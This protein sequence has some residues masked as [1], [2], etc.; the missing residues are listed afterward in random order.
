MPQLY[1]NLGLALKNEDDAAQAI[2]ELQHAEKLDATAPEAP[3]LLGVLYMQGGRYAE[4]SRELQTSLRLRPENGDGWAT[5]GSV[6]NKLD[7][8]P[9]AVNALHEAIDHRCCSRA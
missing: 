3:Y 7:Q 9:D 8:L 1:Y 5:L 2:P 6:Y 4:A